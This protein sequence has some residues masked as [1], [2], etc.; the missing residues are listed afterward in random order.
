MRYYD[1]RFVAFRLVNG[2]DFYSNNMNC[3]PVMMVYWEVSFKLVKTPGLKVQYYILSCSQ[4]YGYTDILSLFIFYLNTGKYDLSM[5]FI[6][7]GELIE[8][9]HRYEISTVNKN[10][11]SSGVEISC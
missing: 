8:I 6:F 4:W 3:N 10:Q 11:R 1:T 2:T 9:F 5:G 7:L